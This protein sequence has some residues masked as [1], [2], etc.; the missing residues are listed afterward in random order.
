MTHGSDG[1][2]GKEPKCLFKWIIVLHILCSLYILCIPFN[3]GE[4][5]CVSFIFI[6]FIAILSFVFD[7]KN[8]RVVNWNLNLYVLLINEL[9]IEKSRKRR[10]EEKDFFKICESSHSK[11]S[12]C[13]NLCYARKKRIAWIFAHDCFWYHIICILCI[14]CENGVI[15]YSQKLPYP[16]LH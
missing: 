14:T 8:R 2:S 1:K 5:I 12:N 11:F 7:E 4:L 10:L 6:F 16:H 15:L 9:I 13:V 3:T